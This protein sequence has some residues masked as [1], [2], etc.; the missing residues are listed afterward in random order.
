MNEWI[1]V[2]D[3]LPED[4]GRY[5]AFCGH[6]QWGERRYKLASFLKEA[7]WIDASDITHWQPLPQPP[8]QES[9]DER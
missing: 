6:A 7:G 1:S 8:E 4:T 2:K 5:L 9:D 3:Q